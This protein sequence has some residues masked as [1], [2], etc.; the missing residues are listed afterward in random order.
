[1]TN[2]VFVELAD[3]PTT[4]K[5]FVRANPDN[6]FTIVINSR[7]SYESRIIRYDHEIRHIKNGDYDHDR[8]ESVQTVE[9]R[10]HAGIPRISRKV[11]KK[12]KRQRYTAKLRLARKRAELRESL[13]ID[14]L[15]AAHER[16]LDP[17][18][19]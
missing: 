12:R 7:L 9:A 14:P 3:M 5:S 10:A 19:R 17:D 16:F 1:M 15:A 8:D 18:R 13:G 11:V 4:V 6:S 2:D